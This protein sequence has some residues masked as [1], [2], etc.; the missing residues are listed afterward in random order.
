MPGALVG[1]ASC[2]RC[3]SLQ[4]SAGVL[5]QSC[6]TVLTPAAQGNVLGTYTPL[7]AGVAR[8]SAVRNYLAVLIDVLPLAIAAAAA[9]LAGA[10]G[11]RQMLIL[12]GLLTV[13]LVAAQLLVFLHRGRTLGRLAF[14]LRTVDDLTGNPVGVRKI[15]AGFAS[16]HWM[17]RTVTADLRRGR[18]PLT[19]ALP[20]LPESAIAEASRVD[21]AVFATSGAGRAGT[22]TSDA[23]VIV[24][25][26]GRRQVISTSLLIGRSPESKDQQPVLALADLSRTLSKTHALLEWSG[27]VLWVTDLHS[28]NG[29]VLISPEGERRPLVPGIRGPAAIGWTVEC[30]SRSFT[31]HAV[32]QRAAP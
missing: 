2:A 18:D 12:I 27:S 3:G 7:L 25:D 20:P 9:V 8:S 29:S 32:P 5:C 17:R 23:V 4:T 1:V 14:S 19:R 31:V 26:T 10:S 30:G 11:A 22:A 28:A 24:F 16:S 6:G 15:I 13:V 21:S